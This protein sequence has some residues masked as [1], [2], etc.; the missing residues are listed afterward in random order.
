MVCIHYF[1]GQ[2]KF[3]GPKCHSAFD[4]YFLIQDLRWGY[5]H[6]ASKERSG[7]V[8]MGGVTLWVSLGVRDDIP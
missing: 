6:G 7:V 3:R 1:A 5:G 4:R 8:H 2:Y